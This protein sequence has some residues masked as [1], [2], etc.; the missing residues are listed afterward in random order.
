MCPTQSGQ[1]RM[2]KTFITFLFAIIASTGTIF[3]ENV[4]VKIGDL[5]YV[6]NTESKTAKVVYEKYFDSSNYYGLTSVT[7]P[8]E[9]VYEDE[10]YPVTSIYDGAFELCS[11]L[12]SIT[13]G[14]N[15][16]SFGIAVFR[17]TNLNSVIWNAKKCQDFNGSTKPFICNYYN[18]SEQITSLTFGNDVEY[19]P[20]YLCYQLK[21]ITNLV[22]PD[23]VTVIG[24]YAFC[25]CE[26]LASIKISEKLT[27]IK[28]YAFY[29]CTS[30]TSVIIPNNV[31]HIEGCAFDNCRNLSAVTIP[32]SVTKIGYIAFCSTG[33]T[34]VVI[35][36]SV[37]YLGHMAFSDCKKLTSVTISNN[38]T[39]IQHSVF[40]G[41]SSLSTITI[42]NSV[43]KIDECAFA[44]TGIT[45]VVIPNSVT[46]LGHMIFANCSKLASVT[47]GDNITRIKDHMFA[48]CT[49]LT[50]IMIPK[51]VTSIETNAFLNCNHLNK[52]KCAALLP[53]EMGTEVFAQVDCSKIPLFVPSG[54]IAAYS[55]TEQWKDFNPIQALDM[56]AVE[57]VQGISHSSKIIKDGQLIISH[58][59]EMYNA[60]GARVE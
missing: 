3:A 20:A 22:I 4:R 55:T 28:E 25:N 39:H 24:A 46:E 11:T 41:C 19:I 8:D 54:S 32:N 12:T 9:V 49:S 58:D 5:Y 33:L 57:N 26:G 35:P 1:M 2:K 51:S 59:G 44:G 15:V 50:E 23:N 31:L 52:V 45:S 53:P 38:L 13:I 47:M 30:L 17:Y 16:T 43:T 42:P 37:T 29:A 14:K 21:K 10:T 6:I 60:Q 40:A 18:F 56:D 36:N 27:D 48:G 7:I 34:S